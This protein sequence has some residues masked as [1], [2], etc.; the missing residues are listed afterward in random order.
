MV[1]LKAQGSD[2][3][4]EGLVR[5]SC[6]AAAGDR[7]SVRTVDDRSSVQSVDLL[8][9]PMRFWY[10][11]SL[12]HSDTIPAPRDAPHW[13]DDAEVADRILL[14]GNGPC[15]GWGVTTHDLAL[16][17]QLG[18]QLARLTGR[19]CAVDYIGSE[20]M[21]VDTAEE[22][23]RAWPRRDYDAAVVILGIND[24]V[25]LTSPRRWARKLQ[26]LLQR[27]E[28]ELPA[29]AD[30]VLGDIPPLRS[31]GGYDNIIGRLV[32]PR[33]DELNLALRGLAA[34]SERVH[35]FTVPP[36]PKGDTATVTSAAAGYEGLG[37][38]L[39]GE[40]A[41][42]LPSERVRGRSAAD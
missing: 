41:S 11:T 22:E 38:L 7:R 9:W 23:L 16:T 29:S 20:T 35:L 26:S 36:A 34:A 1:S 3:A 18:R 24:A 30:I 6:A 39:A 28:R 19:G 33:A 13:S 5:Q 15:H 40:I 37:A 8:R 25:R 12:S 17:G 31:L 14:L 27:L 42:N 2:D 21:T 4:D 10:R 32:Q